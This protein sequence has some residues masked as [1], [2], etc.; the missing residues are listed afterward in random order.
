MVKNKLAA[1]INL[2]EDNQSL[3]PLTN[4]RPIAALPFAGRYRIIDFVLSS[5]SYAGIDS[6][7]LFIGDSGRS[8]YDHIRS[9][10][11][12]DLQSSIGGGVF[13]FSQQNWKHRY[14]I[15][16][17]HE[18]YYYNHRIYLQR[19]HSD[20]V[21]VSGSSIISNNN[22][23]AVT[24]QHVASGADITMIYKSQSAFE[25]R[26][27][28][29]LV[30]EALILDEEGRFKDIVPF[31]EVLNDEK[32]HS[33]LGK[34]IIS[35]QT[36]LDLIDRATAE[37]VYMNIN[38]LIHFYLMDYSVNTYEY[39]GYA[40]NIDT[41]GAYYSANMEMLSRSKFT[42]LFHGSIPVLTKT[43]HG[44]PTYY[45]ENSNAREV[46]VGTDSYIGGTV[47]RSVLNRRVTVGEGAQVSDS[48]ILQGTK[49]GEN[50]E[51][52]Y[53]IIDKNT[54]IEPGAKIIGTPDNLIV[55]GKGSH[56]NA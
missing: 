53:A 36:L 14:R 30:D 22:L 39:T 33:S 52:R 55:I 8:I 37:Q 48:I 44:A 38:E 20:Y 41:I 4:N 42:S 10:S 34:Y 46:I 7:A 43:K 32:I 18:D 28:E 23:L 56:I 13:T 21:F 25:D 27:E 19:S 40:A 16:E 9:G 1:I 45:D 11:E 54:V 35:T 15:E 17:E 50:A 31:E 49:I 3:R 26:G 5:I 47:E 2:T 51:I 12:W 29:D 24:Q 6:V